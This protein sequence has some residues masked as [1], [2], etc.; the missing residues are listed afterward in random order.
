MSTEKLEQVRDWHARLVKS[1]SSDAT[2]GLHYQMADAIDA[3][4]KARGEVVYEV[5]MFDGPNRWHEV[6]K[7]EY[8]RYSEHTR[9]TLYTAPPATKIDDAMVER[10]RSA[11]V[12]ADDGGTGITDAMHAALEAALEVTP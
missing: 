3:E 5:R 12:Q 9:R 4:L 6:E 2:A 11:F 10:A 8:E 1:S 7:D